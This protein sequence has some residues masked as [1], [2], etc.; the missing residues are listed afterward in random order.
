MSALV[1]AHS[2]HKTQATSSIV[3]VGTNHTSGDETGIVSAFF[4]SVKV[5]LGHEINPKSNERPEVPGND[6]LNI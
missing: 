4:I 6:L 5:L 1:E 3:P 2:F